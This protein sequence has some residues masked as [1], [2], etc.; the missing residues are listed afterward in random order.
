MKAAMKVRTSQ[1]EKV[2]VNSEVSKLAI[3]TMT[4]GA[5]LLG[6]WV[7]TAFVGGIMSSGGIAPLVSNWIQ[8]VVG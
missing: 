8:A 6:M 5:G 3:G 2:D 1:V 7:V 4:V